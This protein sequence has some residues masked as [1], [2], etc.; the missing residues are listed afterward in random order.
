MI[1][2]VILTGFVSGR[3]KP[4]LKY[5]P[6]GECIATFYLE[7]NALKKNADGGNRTEL[8]YHKITAWKTTVRDIERLAAVD[9]YLL[10]EGQL[11]SDQYKRGG[12][13]ITTMSVVANHISYIAKRKPKGNE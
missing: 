5:F 9:N 8:D 1:N 13:E 4:E 10:V 2:K 7:Y 6:N 11:K 3:I 12:I